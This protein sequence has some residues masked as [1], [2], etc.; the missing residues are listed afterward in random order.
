MREVIEHLHS[1]VND[2]IE[3]LGWSLTP[4][5]EA[6]IPEIVN[7]NDRL[8]VAPTGSGKTESAVLPIISKCLTE[9]WSGLSIL[10]ITPLRAL[11]RDI[12]RRLSKMLKPVGLS[13][14][15]RHGDTSQKKELN[16]QKNLQIYL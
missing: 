8:L 11:N 10:Y 3:D 12:D 6:A 5:Q 7:G 1:S 13:V 4:I 15:L 16:S 14:G 2:L 9:N